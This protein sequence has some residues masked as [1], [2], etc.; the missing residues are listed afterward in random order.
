[1][2]QMVE[3]IPQLEEKTF[4]PWQRRL[5]ES[6]FAI[7]GSLFITGLINVFQLY[8]RIP[9]I[10]MLYLLLILPLASTFGLYIASLASIAA[11]LAFDFFLVPPFYTFTIDRW[12][13]WIALFVFLATALL[14]S[15]LAVLMRER[16][17]LA[18][19][20]E[21][22]ARILYELIRLTNAQERLEQQLNVLVLS[23]V[24]VFAA[25]GVRACAIILLDEHGT[26]VLLNDAT[27]DDEPPFALSTDE[28]TIAVAALSQKR[29]MEKRE[30]P[31]PD[32]RDTVNHVTHYNT[33][34]PVHL[35]RLLPLKSRDETLGL[36][37]L[38]IQRPAPW[39][40]DE[41]RMQQEQ[42]RPNSRI[43]FFWTFMEQATSIVE[44]AQLRAKAL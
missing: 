33:L 43:D 4:V 37:C 41:R 20:R 21:R 7:G 23:M 25:W 26:L 35:L 44:R 30:G 36:L 12:E 31:L 34:E 38:R 29:M 11:F 40:A 15:Q 13:E 9:N 22:E 8:P 16:T 27:L 3:R 5:L 6:L 24:H 1:M 14:T 2:V 42:A 28:R 17:A 10:S 32:H 19:R 39:F 18:Q